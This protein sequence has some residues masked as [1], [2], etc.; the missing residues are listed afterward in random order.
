MFPIEERWFQE[1]LHV[2]FSSL[3]SPPVMMWRVMSLSVS[4]TNHNGGP[5]RILL[6]KGSHWLVYGL[7]VASITVHLLR[8]LI[9]P[10]CHISFPSANKNVPCPND[11]IHFNQ[12][13]FAWN[14]HVTGA[15]G[16]WCTLAAWA[17]KWRVEKCQTQ[18][19]SGR[20]ASKID[21][22]ECNF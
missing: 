22:T 9:F 19:E 18:N 16:W 17:I 3:F 21:G 8:S 13:K 6:T 20:L 11:L 7:P 12:P 5:G 2:A 14:H 10:S 4:A 15:S 1:A